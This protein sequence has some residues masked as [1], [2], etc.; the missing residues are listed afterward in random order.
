MKTIT[1]T[2]EPHKLIVLDRDDGGYHSGHCLLCREYGWSNTSRTVQNLGV[3]FGARIRNEKLLGN[4]IEHAEDCQ[5]GQILNDD[6]S[7]KHGEK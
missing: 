1:I 4:E 2:I 3:P 6:G 7:F 5:L